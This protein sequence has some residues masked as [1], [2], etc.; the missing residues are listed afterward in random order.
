MKISAKTSLN[1]TFC[2]KLIFFLVTCFKETN[3]L[4]KSTRF[5]CI[6]TSKYAN[7]HL[8]RRFPVLDQLLIT[9]LF[10]PKTFSGSVKSRLLSMR[11]RNT[12]LA[13]K[14]IIIIIPITITM[15]IIIRCS[16]KTA[17]V[18]TLLP[19]QPLVSKIITL[20]M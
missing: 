8:K 7:L 9:G 11:T 5:S 3:L 14:F 15:F 19:A 16:G 4:R 13:Y 1:S 20:Y 10:I 12:D 17:H 2:S 18:A 6:S